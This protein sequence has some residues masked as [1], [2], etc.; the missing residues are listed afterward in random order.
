MLPSV[1]CVQSLSYNFMFYFNKEAEAFLAPF[2]K[3]LCYNLIGQGKIK[4]EM[5]LV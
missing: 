4:P 1:I 5:V 2:V 3:S